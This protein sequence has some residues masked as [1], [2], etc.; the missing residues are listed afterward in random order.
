MPKYDNHNKL[1]SHISKGESEEDI[2]KDFKYRG[3]VSLSSNGKRH[4]VNIS[5]D[6]GAAQSILMVKAMPEIKENLTGE[7]V[8]LKVLSATPS[9]V[10]P[11]Y[12]STV[13]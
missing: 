5:C 10:L 2:F 4:E 7:K 13:S 8:I 6:T 3:H 11:R 1:F 9:C 12:I